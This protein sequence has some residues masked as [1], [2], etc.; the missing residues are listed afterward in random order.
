METVN[1]LNLQAPFFL[2]CTN[3]VVWVNSAGMSILKEV[4]LRGVWGEKNFDLNFRPD[5]NFLIGSNGSGKTTVINLIA[6]ALTGDYEALGRIPFSSMQCRLFDRSAGTEPLI[7]VYRPESPDTRPALNYEIQRGSVVKKF[8]LA[9]FGHLSFRVGS[10]HIQE[11]GESEQLTRELKRLVNLRWLSVHRAPA[12]IRTVDERTSFDSAVDRRLIHLSNELVRYFSLQFAKRENETA[13]FLR[14][15]FLALVYTSDEGNVIEESKKL[16]LDN[17]ETS[18]ETIFERFRVGNPKILEQLRRHFALAKRAAKKNAY[19]TE[20]LAALVGVR[21]MRRVVELWNQSLERQA[22]LEQPQRQFLEILNSLFKHKRLELN[23]KNELEAILSN[24]KHLS[25]L[26]LSSGEKQL[27]IILGEA[28]IQERAEFIYIADEPELSLHVSWQEHLT[29]NLRRVNPS[30]QV[31]FATHSPDIV[32][33]YGD[34]VI[35]MENL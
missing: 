18:L 22:E 5:V 3:Q 28:L 13:R 21:A 29:A 16:D 35:D 11:L 24:G 1:G 10:R 6:A 30:A 4:S 23:Q 32:S 15:L 34:R 2:L 14:Q 19:S 25:L 33:E 9:H 17:L 8:E 26:D 27:L 7:T 31:I 20:E 12:K